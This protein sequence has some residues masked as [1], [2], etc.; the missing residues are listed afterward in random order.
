MDSNQV[1]LNRLSRWTYSANVFLKIETETENISQKENI[2]HNICILELDINTQQ[3]LNLKFR[4]DDCEKIFESLIKN[5][6]D[7]ASN[8]D[9]A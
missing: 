3:D 6:K 1:P 9:I 5:A 8:G 7:I 4:P 2:K